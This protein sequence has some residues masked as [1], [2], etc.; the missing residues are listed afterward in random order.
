MKTIL[1]ISALT[2]LCVVSY[3]SAGNPMIKAYARTCQKQE[4]ASEADVDK[5]ADGIVPE[6]PEGK[7][8]SGKHGSKAFLQ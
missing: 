6:T 5:L 4:N 7:C 2:F 8:L 1:I 3:T